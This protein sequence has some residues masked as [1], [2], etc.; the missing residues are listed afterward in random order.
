[1]RRTLFVFLMIP[2]GFL[3]G[4]LIG[5]AAVPPAWAASLWVTIDASMNAAKYG[6]AFEHT[7]ERALLW[8]LYPGIIGALVSAILSVGITCLTWR[9]RFGLERLLRLV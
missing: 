9:R 1:M 6:S 7:A 2:A 8:F 4:G 3:V 5:W